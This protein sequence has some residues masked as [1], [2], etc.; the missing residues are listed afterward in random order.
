MTA[1]SITGSMD[2]V[3][4]VLRQLFH[5]H[6]DHSAENID[7]IISLHTR[8]LLTGTEAFWKIVAWAGGADVTDED[9]RILAT[10]H[11]QCA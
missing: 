10:T 7:R 11:Y 2:Y 6:M 1:K 9:I 4:D 8:G 3:N 5:A